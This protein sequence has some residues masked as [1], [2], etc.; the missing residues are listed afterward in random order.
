[1]DLN[2][3][4]QNFLGRQMLENSNAQKILI[5]SFSTFVLA[6]NLSFTGNLSYL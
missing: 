4:L 6:E 2:P 1:M 3:P 5:M